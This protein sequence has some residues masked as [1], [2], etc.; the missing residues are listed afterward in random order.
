MNVDVVG[1]VADGL[2]QLRLDVLRGLAGQRADVD[3][4]VDGVGDRVDLRPAVHDVRRERRVGAGVELPGDADRELL[5]GAHEVVR[6]Q[7]GAGQILG[8]VD[9]GDEPPPDVV[10]VGRRGVGGDPADHL[11]RLD[12]GVVGPPGLR[13]V[14]GG[15]PDGDGGPVAALLADHDRELQARRPTG[16]GCHRTP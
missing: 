1:E 8:Q 6:G 4:E 3:L 11:G 5:D 7:Q 12:Q 2:A 14:A 16:S 13:A 10:D 9:A 15:A